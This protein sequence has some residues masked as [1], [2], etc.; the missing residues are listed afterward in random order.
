MLIMEVCRKSVVYP[1]LTPLRFFLALMVILFHVHEFCKNRGFPYFD[2]WPLLK[3]GTESV[4]VFFTLSGFLI[5][6]GLYLEKEKIGRISLQNFFIKRAFRILPLYYTVLFFGFIYYRLILPRLGFTIDSS[7]D[8]VEGV[9][10]SVTLFANVFANYSPGGIIEILWSIAIEEQFY[11]FIAPL[12][13]FLP[14]KRYLVFLTLFSL[15]Y[16]IVYFYS[17]LD[18]FRSN[19]MLYFYF[20]A[21]GLAAVLLD[22]KGF[23]EFIGRIR[24]FIYCGIL[25]YFTTFFFNDYMSVPF[26]HFSGMILIALFISAMGLYPLRWLEHKVLYQLGNISYGMYMLHPIVMQF[27]GFLFLKKLFPVDNSFSAIIIFNLLVVVLTVLLSFI[28]K[29][30]FEGYFIGLRDKILTNKKL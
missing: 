29:R 23:C 1:N 12:L 3:K 5:I 24:G 28:S 17:P 10:L 20:T 16:F 4:Y 19:R 9:L 22:K 13:S 25:I 27:V 21:G 26:F 15:L 8:L 11:L 2:S 6:R 14:V 7:Y 18:F 30:Y